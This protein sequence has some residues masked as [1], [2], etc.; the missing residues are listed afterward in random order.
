MKSRNISYLK[1]PPLNSIKILGILISSFAIVPFLMPFAYFP[2]NK[3]FSEFYS[4]IVALVVFVV[5]ASQNRSLKLSSVTIACFAFA[6]FIAI[7]PVFTNITL[8]SINL[9]LCLQFLTLGLFS[10]AVTSLANDENLDSTGLRKYMLDS[11][12]YGLLI[13]GVLQSLIGCNYI[14]VL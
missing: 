9:Y 1:L 4:L 13:S 11:L 3:F 6:V 8:L 5:F 7:Q 14:F 2:I 12:C 10:L